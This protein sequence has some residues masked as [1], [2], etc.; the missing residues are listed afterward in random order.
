LNPAGRTNGEEDVTH[1]R[2]EARYCRNS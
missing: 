1:T 2:T